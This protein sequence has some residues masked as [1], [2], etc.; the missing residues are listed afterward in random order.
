MSFIACD[1]ATYLSSDSNFQKRFVVWIWQWIRQWL[2]WMY[3][4]EMLYI[5]KKRCDMFSVELKTWAK[6]NI[7]VF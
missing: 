3:L 5:I 7:P 4:A 1:Q 6:K 2:S